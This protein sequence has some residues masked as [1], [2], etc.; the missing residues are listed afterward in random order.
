VALSVDYMI[1][2]SHCDQVPPRRPTPTCGWRRLD[3]LWGFLTGWTGGGGGR[4][5]KSHTYNSWLIAIPSDDVQSLLL[6]YFFLITE[7]HPTLV[8]VV[9]PWGLV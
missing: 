5:Y 6:R 2:G 4:G 9:F 3:G 7:G 1:I 8:R